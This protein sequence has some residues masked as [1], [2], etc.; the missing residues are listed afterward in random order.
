MPRL[1]R[2]CRALLRQFT[3]FNFDAYFA[4]FDVGATSSCIGID[5][6]SGDPVPL[7]ATQPPG[8]GAQ[9]QV[10]VLPRAPK[11]LWLSGAAEGACWHNASESWDCSGTVLSCGSKRQLRGENRVN[12]VRHLFLFAALGTGDG[13][14]RAEVTHLDKWFPAMSAVVVPHAVWQAI[15]P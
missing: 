6:R 1:G 15:W 10:Q 12:C 9:W 8:T 5:S 2:W 11:R 4:S 3:P 7:A 13:L 14:L